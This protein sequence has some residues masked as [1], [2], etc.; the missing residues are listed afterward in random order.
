[1]PSYPDLTLRQLTDVVAYLKS[2]TTGGAAEVRA[3]AP[4]APGPDLPAPPADPTTYY[5]V[6]AYD[7]LPGRL[8]EFEACFRD[9]GARAFLAHDG[10]A[11]VDT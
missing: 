1:M 11:R 3:A 8:G 9:Q 6:Q 2:L 7:V 5:Y 10:L 4:P